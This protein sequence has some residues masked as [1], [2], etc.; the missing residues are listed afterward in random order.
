MG[1]MFYFFFRYMLVDIFFCNMG[2]YR[3]RYIFGFNIL[4]GNLKV[5]NYLYNLKF[6]KKFSCLYILKIGII[7][8]YINIEIN[9]SFYF[10]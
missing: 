2:I 6:E 4:L 8:F 10:R 7:I 1:D 5:F 3:I 9:F